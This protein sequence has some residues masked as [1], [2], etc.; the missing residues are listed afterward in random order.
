M[1]YNIGGAVPA[2]SDDNNKVKPRTERVRPKQAV[3]PEL[4]DMLAILNDMLS[5]HV[6]VGEGKRLRSIPIIEA[7]LEAHMNKALSD[8]RALETILTLREKY[9]SL[10]SQAD[11]ERKSE[12][13]RAVDYVDSKFDQ[14]AAAL[15]N[16][17]PRIETEE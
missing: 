15:G 1:G 3:K 17:R 7:A 5:K 11:A 4:R 12:M 8:G 9:E 13:K 10:G 14:I 16:P 6:L 2:D